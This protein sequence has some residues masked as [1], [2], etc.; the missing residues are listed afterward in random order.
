MY[1][2]VGRR[3]GR[4]NHEGRAMPD[5]VVIDGGIGQ[6]GSANEAFR[7]LQIQPPPLIGLAKR[8]ETIVFGDEHGEL[9]L[10][11]R[12]PALRLLQRLLMRPTG[13][14]TSLMPILE[15][16]RSGNPCSMIFLGWARSNERCCWTSLARSM[17]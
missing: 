3:Y 14:P 13:L 16:K 12:D 2:V 5:L 11:K 15:V 9:K 6:V 17:P 4:L 10:P 1:E 7:E 8:E